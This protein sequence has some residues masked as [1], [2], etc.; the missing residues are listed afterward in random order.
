[1]RK[2]WAIATLNLLVLGGISVPAIWAILGGHALS[3]IGAPDALTWGMAA[4]GPLALLV[5]AVLAVRLHRRDGAPKEA[6][7]AA[8]AADLPGSVGVNADDVAKSRLSRF[9]RPADLAEDRAPTEAEPVEFDAEDE[10]EDDVHPSDGMSG[11]Q[12]RHAE[13]VSDPE[14]AAF[15]DAEDHPSWADEP[16]PHQSEDVAHSP[17]ADAQQPDETAIWPKTGDDV[18][19][20]DV[21][22]PGDALPPADESVDDLAPAPEAPPASPPFEAQDAEAMPV[23]SRELPPIADWEAAEEAVEREPLEPMDFGFA[24]P[25]QDGGPS[26][27]SLLPISRLKF[28]MPAEKHA[29][30]WNWIYRDGGEIVAPAGETGFPWATAGIAHIAGAIV[31]SRLLPMGSQAAA[32]ARGWREAVAGFSR[33]EEIDPADGEAFVGWINSLDT[34]D[35]AALRAAIDGA[36]EA[37]KAEAQRDTA[38]AAC[39]PH[40][41]GVEHGGEA[42]DI[43]LAG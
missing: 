24:G 18:T 36:L 10:A 35:D 33:S 7:D 16:H 27:D 31:A 34:G 2:F 13:P 41:F 26:M 38:L 22:E 19:G 39:L 25:E 21:E 32:E 43:A 37:L 4:V 20:W 3:G 6:V 29:A 28:L 1:M 14:L 11:Y 5:V 23:A 9:A 17:Y 30:Q 42:G 8:I 12:P 40:E 15:P